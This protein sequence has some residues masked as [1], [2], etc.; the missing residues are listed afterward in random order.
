MWSN[1][2]DDTLSRRWFSIAIA[3]LVFAGLFAIAIVVARVPVIDQWMGDPLFFRRCLAVHV[4]LAL[5][6]WFYAFFAALYHLVPARSSSRTPNSISV[7]VGGAAFLAILSG[8]GMRNSEAM[9][10]NYIPIIDHPIF[11]GG[12]LAAGLAIAL[13]FTDLRVFRVAPPSP[14]QLPTASSVGL[15]AAAIAFSLALL[16]FAAGAWAVPHALGGTAYYES[17]VWGGGHVL[18]FTNAMAMVAVWQWLLTL[19]LGDDRAS[20]RVAPWLFGAMLVPLLAAPFVAALGPEYPGG[21]EYFTQIMRWGI[22]P[23]VLVFVGL[24]VRRLRQAASE[25]GWRPIVGDVRVLAV[26]VSVVLTL[27]G[28]VLG[29]LI[30]GQTTMIP[31][32]YH[33]SIGGVT[34]SFMG[35]SY[36][37][38]ERFGRAP[39]GGRALR[40]MR[41]QPL[42]YGIGQLMFAFG[43]GLAGAHGAARKVYGNEQQLRTLAE[44]IGMGTMGIG[45]LIAVAGG[46]MLLLVVVPALIRNPQTAPGAPRRMVWP[47]TAIASTRSKS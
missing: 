35:A 33:A 17:L 2:L 25:R 5:V 42:V 20:D 1:T 23:A 13:C 3:S 24:G 22:F 45:G 8:A 26:L 7:W 32:H 16:T 27:A 6:V 28:F 4:T 46:I 10:V 43:F 30:R 34:V 11:K 36:V 31:A 21:R 19:A 37:L 29:A 9:L 44:S 41:I 47:T 40:T 38:L 14:G 12:L 18:Q 15:R 39:V